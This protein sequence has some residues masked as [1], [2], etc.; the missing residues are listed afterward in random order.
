MQRVTL[1]RWE[2]VE[3]MQ[4]NVLIIIYNFIFFKAGMILRTLFVLLFRKQQCNKQSTQAP[5]PI[6]D[7]MLDTY[8]VSE[9]VIYKQCVNYL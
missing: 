1:L 2:N 5:H 4:S 3:I 7:S 9:G 8:D 6:S